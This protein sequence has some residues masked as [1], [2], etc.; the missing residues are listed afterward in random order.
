MSFWLDIR[1]HTREP[2][3]DQTHPTPTH[4]Q[5]QRALATLPAV[6]KPPSKT[7]ISPPSHPPFCCSDKHC[8]L[9]TYDWWYTLLPDVRCKAWPAMQAW[10]KTRNL[11]CAVTPIRVST[12][13]A[14]ASSW[15][16][17][18]VPAQAL[19]PP[20]IWPPLLNS[21]PS[22]PLS[23]PLLFRL[24]FPTLSHFLILSCS[25]PFS[26]NLPSHAPWP[27]LPLMSALS[28]AL[29]YPSPRHHLTPSLLSCHCNICND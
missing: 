24:S 14:A 21:P 27:P 22:A 18:Q 28:C 7:P 15:S 23:S 4:S 11:R 8:M 9:Y 26:P 10:R 20:C 2:L 29:P 3:A 19:D 12:L 16:R 6:S 1:Y 5:Q 17:C 13:M 25:F